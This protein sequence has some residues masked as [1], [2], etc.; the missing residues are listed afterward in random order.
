MVP[1][2]RRIATE[3]RA[4]SPGANWSGPAIENSENTAELGVGGTAES[5]SAWQAEAS[6]PASATVD[7][8]K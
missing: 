5:G 8:P 7:T 3:K 2:A 4:D 1:S 6:R